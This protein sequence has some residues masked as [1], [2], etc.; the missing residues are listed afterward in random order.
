MRS[1]AARGTARRRRRRRGGAQGGRG[2]GGPRPRA[3][4]AWRYLTEQRR[5]GARMSPGG[6]RRMP[7]IVNTHHAEA[8]NGWE[9]D[10][11]ARNPD[12]YDGMMGGVNHAL[13]AAAAIGSGDRVLDVG[14]GTGQTTLLAARRAANGRVTGIDLSAAMLERARAAAA[15][16]GLTHVDF[17]Q[18]DAQVH[19]L[20]SDGYDVAVSRSGVSLFADP[21]AAFAN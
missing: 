14:C 8:W 11:W 5:P 21:V 20:P 2:S 19:P 9:G 1:G 16:Q 12:R 4:R 15:A 13:L 18:G 3:Y 7:P 17:I 10:L 6:G